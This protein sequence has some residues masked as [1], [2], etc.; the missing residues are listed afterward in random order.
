MVYETTT[1]QCTAIRGSLSLLLALANVGCD[2]E[3]RRSLGTTASE[4]HD[5]PGDAGDGDA[6]EAHDGG[7]EGESGEGGGEGESEGASGG[8]SESEG[9]ASES[10]QQ[11]GIPLIDILIVIDD[12]PSMLDEQLEL[13]VTVPQLVDAALGLFSADI[14]IGVITSS[15]STLQGQA[16]GLVLHGGALAT[17]GLSALQIDAWLACALAVGTLGDDDEQQAAS[18][19]GLLEG[20]ADTDGFLRVDAAL[21]VVLV[22]DEDDEHSPGQGSDWAAALQASVALPDHTMMFG[23]LGDD[24]SQCAVA[25]LPSLGGLL[26]IAAQADDAVELRAMIEATP[27]H[28]I[29]SICADDHSAFVAAAVEVMAEVAG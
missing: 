10:E 7:G 25:A 1:L 29:G 19:L 22:S 14:R 2:D 6:D 15:D 23:L 27:H 16:C 5:A 28:A 24:G 18:L 9:N 13:L 8:E 20:D 21:M 3:D 17:E 11:P 26:D 4:G 12:S